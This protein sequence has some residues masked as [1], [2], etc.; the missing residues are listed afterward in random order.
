MFEGIFRWGNFHWEMS[1]ECPGNCPG[2]V[3]EMSRKLY[4]ECPENCPVNV[5]EI[6]RGMSRELSGECPG[7]CL[8]NCPGCV[9]HSGSSIQDYVATCSGYDLYN[10]TRTHTQVVFDRLYYMLSQLPKLKVVS[11]IVDLHNCRND[12]LAQNGKFLNCT[13]LELCKSTW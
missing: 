6:V 11:K 4:G 2:N 1:E 12:L 5:R 3:R 7:N 13:F 10:C 9:S 8:G